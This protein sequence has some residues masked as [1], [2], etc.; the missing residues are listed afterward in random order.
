M[1]IPKLSHDRFCLK[2]SHRSLVPW[3]PPKS[4][5]WLKK[6]VLFSAFTIQVIYLRKP[7]IWALRINCSREVAVWV[8]P[9]TRGGKIHLQAHDLRAFQTKSVMG[10]LWD[11]HFRDLGHPPKFYRVEGA[12]FIDGSSSWWQFIVI[13]MENHWKIITN[14]VFSPKWHLTTNKKGR[15]A[16]HRSPEWGCTKTPILKE[17]RW[18]IKHIRKST[19]DQPYK[20]VPISGSANCFEMTMKCNLLFFSSMCVL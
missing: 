7:G 19:P 20:F 11:D 10:R 6:Y 2:K 9:R 8:P 18:Q 3:S 14:H 17:N 13:C 1:V 12:G 5:T 15:D 4:S 16:G